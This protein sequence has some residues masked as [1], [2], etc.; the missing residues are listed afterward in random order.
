MTHNTRFDIP[1][2]RFPLFALA[3]L[4]YYYYFW[5]YIKLELWWSKQCNALVI[6]Q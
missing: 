5:I 1:K 6:L 2:L 3:L 4:F